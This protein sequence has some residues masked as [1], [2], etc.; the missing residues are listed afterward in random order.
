MNKAYKIETKANFDFNFD[1]NLN[2]VAHNYTW[3]WRHSV[4][5]QHSTV[6][7]STRDI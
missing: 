4:S 1:F 6:S 7:H 2:F 3:S 5:S